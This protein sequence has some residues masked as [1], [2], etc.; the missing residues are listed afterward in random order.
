[1]GKPEEFDSFI[2]SF[3]YKGPKAWDV[4]FCGKG[5]KAVGAEE[6]AGGAGAPAL[7][8]SNGKWAG[9]YHVNRWWG[10]PDIARHIIQLYVNP[11]LLS[12]MAYY[13]VVISI[14]RALIAGRGKGEGKGRPGQG[15]T[16]CRGIFC[17]G[18][19]RLWSMHRS[20]R[21]TGGWG[22]CATGGRAWQIVL[23]TS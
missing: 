3:L 12:R 10:L 15:S 7:L 9:D 4:L 11:R 16:W 17:N 2:L 1:M 14:C 5:Q 8:F 18:S 23:A 6:G 13:D 22:G 21:W 20:L 19:R